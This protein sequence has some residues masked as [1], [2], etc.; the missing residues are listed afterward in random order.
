MVKVL[1]VGVY[2]V[3]LGS[4]FVGVVESFGEIEIY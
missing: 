4:M 2:V 1:V 3:M